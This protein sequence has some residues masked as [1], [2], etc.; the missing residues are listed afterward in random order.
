MLD[1]Q[2]AIIWDQKCHLQLMEP[3]YYKLLLKMFTCGGVFL[4]TDCT[5]QFSPLRWSQN[6]I[7]CFPEEFISVQM[8]PE[9]TMTKRSVFGGCRWKTDVGV[10]NLEWSRSL[11]LPN[12]TFEREREERCNEKAGKVCESEK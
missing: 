4:S 3:H 8:R 11:S 12:P 6:A 10:N 9:S 5:V 2:L 1:T 7:S